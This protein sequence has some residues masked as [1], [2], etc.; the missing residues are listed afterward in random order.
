MLT[1]L[2]GALGLVRDQA[3]APVLRARADA[4]DAFLIAWTVPEFAATLLIED[5]LA[6][7]ARSRRSAS[8]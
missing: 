8:R 5:G 6:L 2:G 3:I 7:R 4:S 1:V